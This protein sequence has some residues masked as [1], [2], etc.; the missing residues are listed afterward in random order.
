[1]NRGT[2]R[3]LKKIFSKHFIIIFSILILSVVLLMGTGYAILKSTSTLNGK[4]SIG[5]ESEE[6][7]NISLTTSVENNWGDTASGMYYGV[8]TVLQNT[9]DQSITSWRIKLKDLEDYKFIVSDYN[10]EVQDNTIHVRAGEYNM[11]QVED[12]VI[13]TN[14]DYNATIEANS[15]ITIYISTA[16]KLDLDVYD[17]NILIDG[18]E[19]SSG[20]SGGESGGDGGETG[21]DGGETGGDGGETGGGES[22]SGNAKLELLEGE[23]P[24]EVRI[25]LITAQAWGSNINEYTVYLTNNTE[26]TMRGWRCNIYFGENATYHEIWVTGDVVNDGTNITFPNNS[27]ITDI[28]PGETIELTLR[29]TTTDAELLPDG[30]AAGTILTEA[31]A[32]YYWY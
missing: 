12:G 7:C 2:K 16:A 14:L 32:S 11:E 21:G 26:S 27:G 30:V 19:G 3:K 20:E 13:L 1:M 4:S 9:T 31:M 17:D 29:L 23:V 6:T 10:A 22:T 25:E 24:L 18:C 8:K 5:S 28:G 15:S